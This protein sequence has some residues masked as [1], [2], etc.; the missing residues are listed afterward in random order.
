[1]S[2]AML[3]FL[4]AQ[5]LRSLWQQPITCWEVFKFHNRAWMAKIKP[6][7]S[8]VTHT[9]KQTPG[10]IQKMKS[11]F[12]WETSLSCKRQRQGHLVSLVLLGCRGILNKLFCYGSGAHQCPSVRRLI[13]YC[14]RVDFS[15]Q[16]CGSVGMSFFLLCYVELSMYTS[17]GFWLKTVFT[18]KRRLTLVPTCWN[19]T[20]VWQS[21]PAV[22]F[23]LF[24]WRCFFVIRNCDTS[25]QNLIHQLVS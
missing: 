10:T 2:K 25:K 24:R 20:N 21:A 19:P 11:I 8:A 5:R 9:L 7:G 16:S 12:S 4:L 17:F 18:W 13:P 3:Q 23:I 1:M 14:L 15:Q 22:T 6:E